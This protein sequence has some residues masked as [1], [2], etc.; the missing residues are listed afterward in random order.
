MKLWIPPACVFLL[1]AAAPA[2]ARKLTFEERIEI[3]RGLTAEYATV[4]VFLPRSKKALPVSQDG[5]YDKAKWD[6]AGREHGPAARVGDLVQITRVGIEDD[7]LI[8]DINGGFKGGRKWYERIEV[9]MGSRTSPISNQTNAP[10]GTTI[11]ILF[12]KGLPAMEASEFKKILKP[13]LDFER[14]SA[15]EQFVETLP[16]PIQ[17]AIKEKRAVEGMD[18]ETVLL[19]LGRP[20]NKVRETKDGVDY[21]DWIYGEPP[22]RIT[23]VTF[24]GSKV[25][26]VKESYAGLGGAVMQPLEPR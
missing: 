12:P 1:A 7:K 20:K 4:K 9:G 23:F 11:A 6:E 15:T 21:E 14:R 8:L 18:R 17:A 5:S 3:T 22:G 24:E 16:E 13:V 26:R 10:G 19:A 2:P 25:V